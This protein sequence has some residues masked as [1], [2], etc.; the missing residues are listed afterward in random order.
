[1]WLHMKWMPLDADSKVFLHKQVQI[2]FMHNVSSNDG[3]L[4]KTFGPVQLLIP[5]ITVTELVTSC[6]SE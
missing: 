2:V 1:M 6:W 3:F 4:C 5:L